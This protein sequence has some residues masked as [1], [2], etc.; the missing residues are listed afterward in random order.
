MTTSV[1]QVMDS[2]SIELITSFVSG[3]GQIEAESINENWQTIGG[4]F[5]A[6]GESDIKIE[7]ISLLT[8][9]AD[10]SGSVRVY[11][12]TEGAIVNRIVRQVNLPGSLYE[13]NGVPVSKTSSKFKVFGGKKYVIQAKCSGPESPN[14][15]LSILNVIPKN[16]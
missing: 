11:D 7:I 12:I 5:T 9:P 13:Q 8:S 4:A 3:P 6:A 15:L 2:G 10:C 16:A 14:N 1:L